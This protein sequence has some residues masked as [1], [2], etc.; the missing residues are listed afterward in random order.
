MDE[1]LAYF[2][3]AVN[4]P[5]SVPPWSE[6]W[7]ANIDLVQQIFPLSEYVRLK[8]RRLR[9][10]RE[11]LQRAGELPKDFRPPHPRTTG[12]CT[13]CGERTSHHTADSDGGHT[14]CP[15]CGFIYQSH[16][17]PASE[18]TNESSPSDHATN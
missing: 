5:A 1:C 17:A 15:T 12:S 10:A 8:H 16:D 9:G 11:I 3:K 7:A 2:R 6:W 4:D 13:E 18:L 14:N